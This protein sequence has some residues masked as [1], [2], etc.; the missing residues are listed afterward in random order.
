MLPHKLLHLR[1]FQSGI[2]IHACYLRVNL[3]YKVQKY[4]TVL[5]AAETDVDTIFPIIFHPIP[6]AALRHPYFERKRESLHLVQ[7][8]YRMFTHLSSF[9][10]KK[11]NLIRLSYFLKLYIIQ[12]T[13]LPL[14][15]SPQGSPYSFHQWTLF[16]RF[17]FFPVSM[18][19]VRV[20][21]LQACLLPVSQTHHP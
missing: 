3:P 16:Y 4:G 15:A 12:S 8:V 6:N 7:V 20:Y 19:S 18:V 14:L 10:S 21:L 1:V 17:P 5:P 13:G 2:Y 9:A 11:D